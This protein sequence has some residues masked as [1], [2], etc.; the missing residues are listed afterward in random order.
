MSLFISEQR[1]SWREGSKS[2]NCYAWIFKQSTESDP[3]GVRVI[4]SRGGH[5]YT[6]VGSKGKLC[7]VKLAFLFHMNDFLSSPSHNQNQKI[8]LVN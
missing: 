5:K 6:Q 3:S 8:P 4:V 1:T 7:P 2:F